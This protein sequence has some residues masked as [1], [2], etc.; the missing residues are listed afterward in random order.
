MAGGGRQFTKRYG[1]QQRR[2]GRRETFT[3]L[4]PPPS[5]MRKTESFCE[6]ASEMARGM[7]SVTKFRDIFCLFISRIIP[8]F[9]VV[10]VLPH[11]EVFR[12]WRNDFWCKHLNKIKKYLGILLRTSFRVL[13][14]LLHCTERRI[15]KKMC[16]RWDCVGTSMIAHFLKFIVV[17]AKTF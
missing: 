4:F 6:N 3:P 14:Y 7:M 11:F 17:D 8:S 1:R 13:F 12:E 2:Y 5:R 16:C 9:R 15:Y 10:Y